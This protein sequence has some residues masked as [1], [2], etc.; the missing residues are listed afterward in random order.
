LLAFISYEKK[1][2]HKVAKQLS[3]WSCHPPLTEFDT[4]QSH[5]S[6]S[7]QTEFDTHLSRQTLKG[8]DTFFFLPERE[9]RGG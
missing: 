9:D 5:P 1:E 6:Y 7:P 3:F 2:R 8:R 4:R